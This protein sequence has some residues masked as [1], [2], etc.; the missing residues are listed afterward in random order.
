MSG[1]AVKAMLSASTG[2][3]KK[4]TV[5]I[6]HQIHD[7][8]GR[9]NQ[10]KNPDLKYLG[11]PYLWKITSE[12]V[13]YKDSYA[14]KNGEWIGASGIPN[15][16]PIN[17]FNGVDS[18][19]ATPAVFPRFANPFSDAAVAATKTAIAH[20]QTTDRAS[21][22]KLSSILKT[23]GS[24]A[25]IGLQFS[26]VFEDGKV[27][28]AGS[29]S[30]SDGG[31]IPVRVLSGLPN[32]IWWPKQQVLDRVPGGA[33]ESP[34]LR[35]VVVDQ[36]KDVVKCRK[37]RKSAQQAFVP[38]TCGCGKVYKHGNISKR[39]VT[40]RSKCITPTP[41][42]NPINHNIPYQHAKPRRPS[43][44]DSEDDED[45]EKSDEDA[46]NDVKEVESDDEGDIESNGGAE[47]AAKAGPDLGSS[48][49][50]AGKTPDGKADPDRSVSE[51]SRSVGRPKRKQAIECQ[52]TMNGASKRRRKSASN[53]PSAVD[54]K[55]SS[56]DAAALERC[57]GVETG[58]LC[59]VC[60]IELFDADE[61]L[62][63]TSLSPA[64][65]RQYHAACV[66]KV[67]GHLYPTLRMPQ[68]RNSTWRSAL[69]CAPR[70]C[71][72]PGSCLD[73]PFLPAATAGPTRI[74]PMTPT[75]GRALI[76]GNAIFVN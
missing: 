27:G 26:R 59:G 42:N 32:P 20:I 38:W 10:L 39:A 12:G 11:E 67:F 47:A 68:P 28:F 57:K 66:Q 16:R 21:A 75:A 61:C 65:E 60:K 50:D 56:P 19:S 25:S 58:L 22:D 40:H 5:V 76:L 29:L 35:T 70:A 13:R 17:L 41:P 1:C 46:V 37:A 15:G 53:A 45:E 71:L 24:D 69:M 4:P 72:R 55:A 52:Q 54:G 49:E 8:A 3:A 63:C 2:R 51:G 44:S 14:S 36:P 23:G 48:A 18:L 7:W 62:E 33:T 30:T 9:A 73:R 74:S 31:Q 34:V 43:P 64:C 6:V